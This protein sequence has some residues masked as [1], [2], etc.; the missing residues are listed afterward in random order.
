MANL[1]ILYSGH[2]EKVSGKQSPDKS[3]REWDFNNQ[4]QY[5]LKNVVKTTTLK[6]I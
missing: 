3:L 6:F 4:I 1:I 2:A 5:K